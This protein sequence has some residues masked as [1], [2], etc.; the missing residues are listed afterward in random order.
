MLC[1][2]AN[3]LYSTAVRIEAVVWADMEERVRRPGRRPALPLHRFIHLAHFLHRSNRFSSLANEFP[4]IAGGG[5]T[6]GRRFVG[7]CCAV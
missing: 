3:L 2:L 7:P 6:E 4:A 5:P 1:W